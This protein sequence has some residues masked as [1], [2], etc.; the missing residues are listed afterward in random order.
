MCILPVVSIAQ[1]VEKGTM[2]GQWIHGGP[3]CATEPE[4]Q[5]HAYN[6]NFYILRQSGCTH[7]EKPFMYL[8]FGSER[9]ILFDTGAGNI[10]I[11]KTVEKIVQKWLDQ[12]GIRREDYTIVV[13]H[14]HS[15]PDHRGG[16]SQFLKQANTIFVRP[17]LKSVISFFKI[18][19]WPTDIVE[20]DLGNRKL[21]IIPVPGH[22]RMHIAAYD[23]Q[24]GILLTGDTVYPG[25]L[26]IDV[27]RDEYTSS[28]K[29]IL[30]FSAKKTVTHVLGGHIEQ[31]IVDYQDYPV[32]TTYQPLERSLQLTIQD[33]QELYDALLTH[34]K[35]LPIR[36]KAMSIC[37]PYPIC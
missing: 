22:D 11:Q 8:F 17:T 16:D 15:H 31:K 36:M 28:I 18:A 3:D 30:D 29:R 4:I 13:N 10:K 27:S 23:R 34:P 35:K 26:Y 14:T 33:V 24:T 21:D 1:Q 12:H 20:Y 2:P 25:R 37:P 19:N 5:V 9:S 32:R 6:T 7:H